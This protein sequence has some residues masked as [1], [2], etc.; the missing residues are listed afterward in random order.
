MTEK[1]SKAI[2]NPR[3]KQ[4]WRVALSVFFIIIATAA[5]VLMTATQYVRDNVLNTNR[6]VEIVSPLPQQSPVAGALATYAT[7]SLF[8]A[9]DTEAELKKFLPPP[10]DPLAAPLAATLKQKAVDVARDFIKSDNFKSIWISAV[11]L[12]HKNLMQVADKD[13]AQNS[14]TNINKATNAVA[15]LDLDGLVSQIEQRFGTNEAVVDAAH[16]VKDLQVDL[17]QDIDQLQ[18]TVSF[19]KAGAYVLPYVF[20]AFMLAAI[21]AAYNRRHAVVAVGLVT[22]LMGAVLLIGFKVGSQ[23][24][25]AG[26][27]NGEYR[28]AAQ[29]V[30]EAFYGDLRHRI[31]VL[32]WAGGIVSVLAI[33]AGP[34]VWAQWLR[35][36]TYI[37]ALQHSRAFAWAR[38][39]RSYLHTYFWWVAGLGLGIILTVL[40]AKSTVTEATLIVMANVLIGF[41]ALLII[42]AFPSPSRRLITPVPVRGKARVPKVTVSRPKRHKKQ[43]PAVV[44]PSRV[45]S[46]TRKTGAAVSAKPANK[47]HRATTPTAAKPVI[48]KSQSPTGKPRKRLEK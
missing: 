18:Q 32:M 25:L 19:I 16:Q 40:L 35:R 42:T 28:A 37:S 17:Q 43:E 46:P 8:N 6:F 7:S 10:L 4:W 1:Q 36:V 21:A 48:H 47:A 45:I 26:I 27:E 3:G 15:N 30:Y 22:I 38:A 24:Y 20:V 41:I 2:T 34:Y 12:L 39:A 29:I 11:Q 23:H 44:R 33:M 9:V 14:P 31:V 13:L 5:M